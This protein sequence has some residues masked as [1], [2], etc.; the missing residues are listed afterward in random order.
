MRGR[1]RMEMRG[2]QRMEMRK[3]GDGYAR[4]DHHGIPFSMKLPPL[5][6]AAG[7]MFAGCCVPISDLVSLGGPLNEHPFGVQAI[8]P[9][10]IALLGIFLAA[11]LY[12]KES[13]RPARAR[14][15]GGLSSFV[16]KLNSILTKYII[17]LQRRS[18]ST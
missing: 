14:A 10:G 8:P 9:V 2:R 1:R 12:K 11:Y 3:G 13:N 6:L 4:G 15:P 5:I 17:L 18:F 7:S 16:S